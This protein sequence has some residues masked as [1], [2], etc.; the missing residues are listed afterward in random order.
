MGAAHFRR[1]YGAGLTH[2]VCHAD[3][4]ATTIRNR[5]RAAGI[6]VYEERK[7]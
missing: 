1:A 5:P 7:K 3:D 4:A 6:S 2:A